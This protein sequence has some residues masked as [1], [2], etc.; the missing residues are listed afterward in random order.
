MSIQERKLSFYFLSMEI[1]NDEGE[2]ANSFSQDK[3]KKFCDYVATADATSK[4]IDIKQANKAVELASL[5][6]YDKQG[7]KFLRG[8]VLSGKYNHSPDYLSKKINY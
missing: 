7:I 6:L 1:K 8:L 3:L 5:N 2:K 4:I